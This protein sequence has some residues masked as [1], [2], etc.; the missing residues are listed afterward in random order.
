MPKI[1]KM[2]R[3]ELGRDLME[4]NFSWDMFWNPALALTNVLITICELSTTHRLLKEK[5][6]FSVTLDIGLMLQ[7]HSFSDTTR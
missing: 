5:C 6:D 4:N 1:S 3:I 7:S 2:L